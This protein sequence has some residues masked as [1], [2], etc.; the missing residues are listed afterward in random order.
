MWIG[1]ARVST[2][3]QETA[4][5]LAAL[6]A[7]G[8]SIIHEERR[9][10]SGARPVLE[11][12]LASLVPGQTVV[13]YKIDRLAR[14]LID[15]LRI[16][17]KLTAIGCG[18]RSLTE[19]LETES[20][21]GRMMIQMLGAVAE[22]ERAVIRERCEA[23]RI[24]AVLRGV[25]FGPPPKIA[26]DDALS[27]R[28]AGYTVDQIAALRQVGRSTVKRALSGNRKCDGGPGDHRGRPPRSG[29]S[30]TNA[31]PK[32]TRRPKTTP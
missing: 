29:L 27:L 20:P 6:S 32:G 3:Q 2:R 15:L 28:R 13:V 16:L 12:M 23:G 14:S 8:V 4:L 17:A 19:P 9:S 10:G 22:F 21:A 24:E 1:Y 25:R 11:A 7:A 18:F 30:N 26:G 5:Q 31:A